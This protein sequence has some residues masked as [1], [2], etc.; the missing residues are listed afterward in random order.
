MDWI[1]AALLTGLLSTFMP[2]YSAD[3]A[4]AEWNQGRYGCQRGDRLNIQ[5][6]DMSPD[7]IIEG[8]RFARGRCASTSTDGATAKP[9]YLSAKATISLDTPATI[10][11]ARASMRLRFPPS[12]ASA[13]L[14]ASTVSMFR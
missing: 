11:C 7:P 2:H 4:A 13:T 5:D 1:K 12:R 8:Q 9:T 6:L 3:L 10:K 14:A